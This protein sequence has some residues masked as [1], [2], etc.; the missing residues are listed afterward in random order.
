[1]NPR[2]E[3]KDIAPTLSEW[4]H[5]EGY[6][7]PS[8]YFERLSYNVLEYVEETKKLE[9]YFQSLPNQVMSKVKQEEKGK[10][11]PIRSYYK[12]GLAA[13]ILIVAG[14]ILWSTVIEE[15]IAPTYSMI[16]YSEDLDYIIN[17]ISIEDI[18]DSE[19]IDDE[20]LDEILVS[21]EEQYSADDSA[22]D[23]LFDADDELLEEFL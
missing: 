21:G 3:I 10:V 2:E 17:E 1:M 7:V 12:Y 6:T 15:T 4:K 22:E 23:V 14:T 19:F 5:S 8:N 13:A 18:F 11:M 16:E 9:P 20:S